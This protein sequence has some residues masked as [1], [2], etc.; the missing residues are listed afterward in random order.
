MSGIKMVKDG[1]NEKLKL[2]LTRSQSSKATARIYSVYQ[3]LQTKKFMTQNASEGEV[4]KP[5]QS[6]YADYKKKKYGSW[7]G[8]GT[9]TLIRTG[10][11]AGA[12]IGPGAPF[13]GTD[14]H[15]AMF[16]TGSMTIRVNQSGVNAEGKP[17]TYPQY[18][19]EKRPFMEFSQASLDKMKDAL[20]KYMIGG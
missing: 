3:A 11:L 9:K 17:F 13:E 14:H 16:S 19:A 6:E 20:K 1:I 2:M 4:W 10:T 5:L 18:V 8:G 7:P 12:V 15:T